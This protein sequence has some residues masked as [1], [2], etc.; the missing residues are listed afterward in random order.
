MAVTLFDIKSRSI[1]ADGLSFGEAGQYEFV[2][3][4][5]HY[6]IDPKHP[7][8]ELVTDINIAS[9]AENGKV[10]FASDIQLLRPINPKPDSSLLLSIVNRGGRSSM[11]FNDAPNVWPTQEPDPPALG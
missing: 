11:I 2:E 8:N 4:T 6:E 10:Q 1:L 3:G 7:D 5:L 9:T